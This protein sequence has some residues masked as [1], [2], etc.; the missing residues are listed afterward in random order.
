MW[1]SMQRLTEESG[2][3]Y[4]KGAPR[5]A[6]RHYLGANSIFVDAIT[7]MW[8]NRTPTEAVKMLAQDDII[9][10]NAG[11]KAVQLK[12]IQDEIDRATR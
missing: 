7:E 4:D 12:K 6:V 5:C 3:V 2:L 11:D 10:T 9:V 1:L 8:E